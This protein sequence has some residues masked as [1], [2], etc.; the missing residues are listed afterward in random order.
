MKT[1]DFTRIS[2]N[3][4][5]KS[6]IQQSASDVLI[7]LLNIKPM[8]SLLDI[9]CGTGKITQKLSFITNGKI[10]GIDPSIGMIEKAKEENTGSRIKFEISAAENLN[11]SEEFDII[12]SN[13]AMQW[14]K[15]ITIALTNF[16]RA[17]KKDGKLG[18]QAPA[19]INYCSN[20]IEGIER[21]CHDERTKKI[22]SKFHS[23]WLFYDTEEEYKV[24]LEQ[25]GFLPEICRIEK[26]ETKHKPDEAYKIFSSGAAAGYLNQEFYDVEINE[27]YLNDFN[28]IIQ[29]EFENQVDELGFVSLIFYRIYM[30][31]KKIRVV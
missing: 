23:P 26:I 9:G 31:A 19:K 20:F 27:N 25:C 28:A 12:F 14:F 6:I 5:D 1:T 11:F 21:V 2:K 17:L 22:F 3:Y 24:K 4:S 30:I 7:G 15:N 10:V 13:S 16:N 18:I 8:D 29:S